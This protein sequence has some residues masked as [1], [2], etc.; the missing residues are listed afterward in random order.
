MG[1]ETVNSISSKYADLLPPFVLFTMQI[2]S[3]TNIWRRKKK[4]KKDSLFRAW[5]RLTLCLM[6]VCCVVL[7]CAD[8]CQWQ[9]DASQWAHVGD[10]VRNWTEQSTVNRFFCHRTNGVD[11]F[12][13][14][15]FCNRT[16]QK[17]EK[18]H[19]LALRTAKQ[20]QIFLRAERLHGLSVQTP[21]A[22]RLL[23]NVHWAPI[24]LQH[25]QLFVLLHELSI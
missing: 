22:L 8:R 17:P 15:V 12:D 7:C 9:S 18:D 6:C 5:R 1:S 20:K 25:V 21:G 16:K 19:T 10:Y 11:T 23:A 3:K 13:F 14:L 2:V 4:K 24:F